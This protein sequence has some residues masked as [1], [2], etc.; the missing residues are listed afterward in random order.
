MKAPEKINPRDGS[1][2]L[3]V[4]TKAVFQAGFNWSVIEKKWPG[5]EQAFDNFDPFIV[6]TYSDSKLSELAADTRIV[7][8]RSKIEAT[9]HNAQVIVDKTNEFGTFKA[10][11]DSLGD[12]ETTVK[13]LRK[14]LKWLGDF[15]A[16]YFLW[17]VNQP[18]P[19]YE[20]WCRL[21]GVKPMAIDN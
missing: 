16:Y 14:N 13:T 3:R 11:L 9:V 4:L 10:Y 20:D 8:N 2:Y 17:V 12:F 5:F 7:R 19:S 21:R 15:G 18:V 6:A 1:D